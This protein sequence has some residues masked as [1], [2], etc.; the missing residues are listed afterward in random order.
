MA[1]SKMVVDLFK[2][3]FFGGAPE[4]G[5]MAESAV[6]TLP[7]SDHLVMGKGPATLKAL[8]GLRYA[9]RIVERSERIHLG[10]KAQATTKDT[11]FIGEAGTEEEQAIAIDDGFGERGGYYWG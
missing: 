10:I 6:A 5:V 1:L 9:G 7:H 2:K 4:V 8:N 3:C 11:D